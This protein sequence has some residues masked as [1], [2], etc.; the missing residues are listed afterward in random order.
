[1]N[2]ADTIDHART[3]LVERITAA[4]TVNDHRHTEAQAVVSE[5][6]ESSSPEDIDAELHAQ[7]LPT[8]QEQG[9]ETLRM[10]VRLSPLLVAAGLLRALHRVVLIPGKVRAR[11]SARS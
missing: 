7:G 10:L 6:R 4:S 9:K 11:L 8:L 2:P 1:M 3:A 5:L